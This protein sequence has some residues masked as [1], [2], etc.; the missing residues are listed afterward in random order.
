MVNTSK[1]NM[2]QISELRFMFQMLLFDVNVVPQINNSMCF[3]EEGN[4]NAN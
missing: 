4:D 1:L 3:T 2:F